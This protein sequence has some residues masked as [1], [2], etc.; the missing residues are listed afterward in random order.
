MSLLKTA[1]SATPA[2]GSRVLRLPQV[3]A[4]TGL[5]RSIIYQMQAERRFPQRVRLTDRAVGW[6]EDE[7]LEWLASR[8]AERRDFASQP[9]RKR[10]G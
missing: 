10:G 7:V 4:L 5:G 2:H 8:A 6:M 1:S 3:C 9:T